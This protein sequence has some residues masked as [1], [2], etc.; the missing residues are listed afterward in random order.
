MISDLRSSDEGVCRILF[1]Q[2]CIYGVKTCIFLPSQERF[3]TNVLTDAYV[4]HR[5]QVSGGFGLQAS[6]PEDRSFRK[7]GV[8]SLE[9]RCGVKVVG[10]NTKDLESCLR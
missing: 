3:R 10:G 1:T 7:F 9:L 4:T 2:G 5:L 8:W 6:D